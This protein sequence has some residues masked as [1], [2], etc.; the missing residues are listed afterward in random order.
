M[1]KQETTE[2]YFRFKNT[3]TPELVSAIAQFIASTP[4]PC[5]VTDALEEALMVGGMTHRD[6][7]VW[8]EKYLPKE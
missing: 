6:I 8:V 3:L 5:D 1:S 4:D 7:A 2:S